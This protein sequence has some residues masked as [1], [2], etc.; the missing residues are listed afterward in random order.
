MAAALL[1]KCIGLLALVLLFYSCCYAFRIREHGVQT[2]SSSAEDPHQAT[3][4]SIFSRCP[5][6]TTATTS[7]GRKWHETPAT[8][9][10][11][12]RKPPAEVTSLD[13]DD[14]GTEK[15]G[16]GKKSVEVDEDDDDEA[17]VEVVEDSD[18]MV[19]GDS[20]AD[21]EEED[22]D[23]EEE[24]Q[25]REDDEEERRKKDR[26]H[27]RRV[28][29]DE[30]E[31]ED[32][33]RKSSRR[34]GNE[35]K[36]TGKKDEA[37]SKVTKTIKDT[38][39]VEDN[40]DEEEKESL[41]KT[42]SKEK[43]LKK[44]R[45]SSVQKKDTEEDDDD[46]ED[47]VDDDGDTD[48]ED[49]EEIKD[50][51]GDD[52]DT[53]DDNGE[54]ED[55]VDENEDEDGDDDDED[56]ES[57]DEDDE[58][59][60]PTPPPKKLEKV[61]YANKDKVRSMET[62][63]PPVVPDKS[64][65][66]AKK[67]PE[68][69]KK[70][71]E[72]TKKVE[73]PTKPV[74]TT[75][76]LTE[77]QEK[78][79]ESPKTVEP[80][81]A[82]K[83]K[84][85][86][87]KVKSS[88][89]SEEKMSVPVKPEV[90]KV[91]PKM[92][93][94]QPKQPEKAK[95]KAVGATPA[96]SVEVKR[97]NKE[98]IDSKG[99][100]KA[101]VEAAFTLAQLNDALL[102]VP[103]FVPN[104]TAVEDFE[105]QQH[106]KIFL[107]QLR[108]YKLWAL[109][110]MDSSAKI[111]SGLL[112][113]NVNQFGDF[114]ECLGVVAYVKLND[115]TL[116]VQGKYCLASIDLYASKPDMKL[117]V[118]L[119]QA[120]GFMKGK[121]HDP[122]HFVPKFPTVKWALCLP[123]ACSAENAETMLV[124]ALNYYNSTTGIKFMVNVDPNM[125]YVKQTSR[126]YS[127]ETIAVL[128]F[129]AMIIC[130]VIVA[131]VRDYLVVSE[132]KGNYSERIIMAFSLRRTVK[133]LL[134][135]TSP[136]E[137]TCIHGI[138]SL[139]TILVYFSHQAV[140][141]SNIPYVNRI[142]FTEFASFPAS[143]FL[144]VGAVYTDTFLLISG[145]LI[146]YN[147]TKEYMT[148][149]EIRW[150]CRFVTRYIRLTPPLLIVVFWYA[151]VMEHTGSGPQWNSLILRNAELCKNNAWTNL[152]Y[153]QNF[154]PVEEMCATHTHQLALD[155]QLSLIAPIL[156]FFLGV[157]PIIG[158]IL[159]FFII[160]LSATLR[161]IA[162]MNNYLSLIVFHGISA[163]NMYRTANLTYMVPLHRATPYVYG[164][165][166][167]VLL[168]YTGKELRIPKV[169]VILGWVI[170][171]ALGSWS[172]F[173]PWHLA[174][175]DYVYN[176]EEATHYA[177][178][179]PVLWGLSISWCIFACHT[180]NGGIINRFL[181]NHWL[182]IISRI[183]YAIYLIQFAVFFHNLGTLR[184][185]IQFQGHRSVDSLEAVVV[186]LVST[187]LTLVFDFPIQEM[188]NVIMESSDVQTVPKKEK[189]NMQTTEENQ[190][191]VKGQETHEKAFEE[192][193]VALT[194]WDWQ[195]DI[196]HG[197]AKLGSETVEDEEQINMPILK[198]SSGRRQS[199]MSHDSPDESAPH[200]DRMK[201]SNVRLSKGVDEYRERR[202]R[203]RSGQRDYRDADTEALEF[204]RL[205]QDREESI[206]RSRRSLSRSRDR[207]RLSTRDSDDEEEY[208]RR[209]DGEEDEDPRRY[210]RSE[211]RGRSVIRES[212]DY[213]SWE[214]VGKERSSSRGPDSKRL[215][216]KSDEYESVQRQTRPSVSRSADARRVLS[217]ESEEEFSQRKKVERRH[218][219]VEPRISDEEDWEGELRIRRKQFMEKL[220]TQQRDPSAE[221]EGLSSPRRR[222]SAE[223]KI[224]LLKDPSA[225]DNMDSWTVSVGPRIAQL[226]SSQERSEPEEDN[227]YLRRREYREQA[228]P[229]REDT[230]SE[231][232]VIWD[233][234]RRRSYTSSSQVTSVEEDEDVSNYNF[235]LTK[236]S[237]RISLHDLSK[238]PHD[239]SE[240]AD[241][242]WNVVRTENSDALP[243]STSLGLY[244]RESII[245]SQASEED[246]EYLLPERPKL[247]QQEREHPFKKAWQ[248]QKSRS[249]EEGS[250]Y[251][252]KESKQ[253]RENKEQMAE[254]GS[255]HDDAPAI[256]KQSGGE[257]Y[258]DIGTFADDESE[259]ITL[260]RSSDTEENRA[261]SKSEE[262]ETTSTGRSESTS[263]EDNKGN[264]KSDTEEDSLKFNWLTE[265][266]QFEVYKTS[267]RRKSEETD[268]TWEQEET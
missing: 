49:V 123:A 43:G 76:K 218:P 102:H 79:T 61:R 141:V 239:D 85:E 261:S 203:S 35:I 167:G 164:I 117:P 126:S 30:D 134:E 150:F 71:E 191:D 1:G 88:P 154:F 22:E 83:P 155:M 127:K 140:V 94:E 34:K 194:G 74:E 116:K 225:D 208:P 97:S 82:T 12:A 156:V 189:P 210:R 54:D 50:S 21:D 77:N 235:I 9:L 110:M 230:Q 81:K 193:E 138:R 186:V 78:A 23:D 157:K 232:E 260:S 44:V 25:L 37:R 66:E 59:E 228:P 177:V 211:S 226:G 244:K 107:R 197:G 40:E 58:E 72:P 36:V 215:S 267:Q 142:D 220:A 181:S 96:K 104:F 52:K 200:W 199:F 87:P 118:H 169:L 171:M 159:I 115:N 233:A 73:T 250:A 209:R 32:D 103:T 57:E 63:S 75:K 185:P 207:K 205:Q 255:R 160:L 121:M 254:T 33:S 45:K 243:R 106:G 68:I 114:D 139:V 238:L 152:L 135:K 39:K 183:S 252:I 64:R 241:S 20:G 80:M 89:K 221:E 99:K 231:E 31:D 137:I 227:A 184:Y 236:D 161:Y 100:T 263:V 14:I 256:K 53:D 192:D 86:S 109:Q 257:Q 42:G 146:A 173:S 120:R 242:G 219:S 180:N 111:P 5:E 265:D 158:I 92:K 201:E 196:V 245:K 18:E 11:N 234:S 84:S 98:K 264:S 105:C 198:K 29:E 217:S 69:M 128:Y 204:S 224:A 153:I 41:K 162:V 125:C 213:R 56:E 131:T 240:L 247:V 124:Q 24:Q 195:K 166:L 130:L 148:R 19:V 132:G 91:P 258:E 143:S 51:E 163:R 93:A 6:K 168:R 259:S 7:T 16:V 133:T 17:I 101:H 65:I 119:M 222:S 122:G 129:Y 95:V 67:P 46:D 175:K 26:Q 27:K 15:G 249:E 145:V 202:E 3:C 212:D 262:M 4:T 60:V 108:G 229:L 28:A 176:V 190:K 149:G 113:G 90:S 165:G 55:D 188:K 147:M 112:R 237:K 144:R 178:L 8:R 174:R 62:E 179:T 248:M 253:P 187:F 2:V 13:D 182:V 136:S 223:G 206:K 268:W 70:Q 172:L 246:P 214:F 10:A 216:S 151:F 48:D 266:E 38:R 251:I 47:E 170:A